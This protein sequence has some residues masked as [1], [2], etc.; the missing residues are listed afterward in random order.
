MNPKI[1]ATMKSV[2]TEDWLDLHVVRPLCYY[3][4]H[5]FNRFDIHPNTITI[6]SM[7]FGVISAYFFAHGSFYYEGTMGVVFNLIAILLL[8]IADILDCT[9]GQLARLSGKK[10]RLGR[11]LD[12]MAGFIWFTP[13]YMALVYRFFLHHTLEFSLL[14]LDES[15]TTILI[16]TL[17]MFV[18]A[19]YSGI[20]G[21]AG[22]QRLADYYIQIHLFFLKGEKGAEL[23]T[24]ERQQQILD[25]MPSSTRPIER[26]FQK[27]YVAYTQKQER[28]TPQFQRLMHLLKQQYG[29]P[30]NAP[31]HI[32][33]Q[34]HDAS[35][36]LMTLNGLLTFNFRSFWLFLFCLI[37]LPVEY[38][39]FEVI[40]MELLCVYINRRHER[41][42]RHVA[43][44]LSS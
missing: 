29:T 32:R 13:I 17:L 36:R 14:G 39:L 43:D 24:S 2:E 15:L 18:L 34:I 7:V 41:F 10:S 22:Q 26:W 35:L 21:I 5:F 3:L 9:D 11:I 30:S 37:D 16:A 1:L 19:L 23:D 31:E 25:E 27:S 4:A 8:S 28:R 33:Q 38:F 42:C 12:G 44:S 20:H 6:W 40:L